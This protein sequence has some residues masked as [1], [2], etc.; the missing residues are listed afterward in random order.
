MYSLYNNN[1]HVMIMIMMIMIIDDA[2][3]GAA[4]IWTRF[5][6]AALSRLGRTH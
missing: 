5:S 2:Y 1:N 3:I 4:G 6:A